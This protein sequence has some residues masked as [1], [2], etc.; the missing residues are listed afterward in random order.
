MNG[1]GVRRHH[2]HLQHWLAA[3]DRAALAAFVDAHG[4]DFTLVRCDGVVLSRDD[5][6]AALQKVGGS[7][8]DLVIDISDISSPTP[9][10]V[11]FLECHTRGTKSE[12]RRVTALVDGDVWLSVHETTVKSPPG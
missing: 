6:V 3:G 1:E 9:G 12:W 4:E 5:M 2:A 8:P 10:A 11:R 7:Q